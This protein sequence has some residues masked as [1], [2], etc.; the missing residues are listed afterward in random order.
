MFKMLIH[1]LYLVVSDTLSKL[2]NY[3]SYRALAYL[4]WIGFYMLLFGPWTLP[5]Y[6]VCFVIALSPISEKLWRIIY[7][8]RPLRLKQEKDRLLPI[9]KEVYLDARWQD[10]TMPR[11]IKLYIQ[12]SMNINAFAF[13]RSTLILTKGSIELLNDDNL[14]GLIAHELGHFANRD[15]LFALISGV[16]NMMLTLTIRVLS[17]AKIKLDEAAKS[18]FFVRFLKI[19]FDVV[20]YWFKLIEFVGGLII[21]HVRRKSEYRADM[22]AY[23]CGYGKE[24]AEVLI[25]IYQTS[26]ERPKSVREMMRASHP[27]ITKRIERLEGE[28]KNNKGLVNE[29]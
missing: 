9:F 20:Y 8:I 23:E 24:L 11:A 12:E 16:T 13:G 29:V 6:L 7:G 27:H 5:I 26:M 18:S 25:Q 19:L 4:L 28:V 3:K 10:R 14:K 2:I 17:A 21:M 1:E 15:T 22:F